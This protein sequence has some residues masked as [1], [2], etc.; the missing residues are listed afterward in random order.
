MKLSILV[1]CFSS[2][3]IVNV[4]AIF[5]SLLIISKLN[6]KVMILWLKNNFLPNYFCLIGRKLLSLYSQTL[7]FFLSCAEITC[8]GWSEAKYCKR[9]DTCTHHVPSKVLVSSLIIYIPFFQ[10]SIPKQ[11]F[12][13]LF[14]Y[15]L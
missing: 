3:L 9:H 14:S 4:L 12:F 15:F 7:V 6:Q 5:V 1:A 11:N 13:K 8:I 2:C 10:K